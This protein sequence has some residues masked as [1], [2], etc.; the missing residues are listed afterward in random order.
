MWLI[1]DDDDD[2]GDDDDDDDDDD[3]DDDD[4]SRTNEEALF[5]YMVPEKITNRCETKSL[6]LVLIFIFITCKVWIQIQYHCMDNIFA[7]RGRQVSQ[8]RIYLDRN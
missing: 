2:D 8:T 1:N 4:I 6:I 5:G 3:N 7:L